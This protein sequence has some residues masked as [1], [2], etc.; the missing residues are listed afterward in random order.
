MTRGEWRGR[1]RAGDLAAAEQEADLHLVP[2]LK[3]LGGPA[4]LDLKIVLTDLQS[5]PDLL[6][7]NLL[8]ILL[9]LG[10][11]FRLLVAVFAPIED[12][13]TGG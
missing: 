10:E 12:F 2:L 9:A 3:E 6:Y 8:L 13:T 4:K 5:E 11:L 7:L 1:V